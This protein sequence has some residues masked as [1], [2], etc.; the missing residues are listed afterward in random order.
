MK[1][2]PGGEYILPSVNFTSVNAI[3]NT[4][5]KRRARMRSEKLCTLQPINA[6]TA[7]TNSPTATWPDTDCKTEVQG[8]HWRES[9]KHRYF[10]PLFLRKAFCFLVAGVHMTSNA[11][12]RIVG[13]HAL[14]ALG[15]RVSTI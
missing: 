8:E 13:Q 12:A 3:P 5:L 1:K 14:D 11:D 15:H 10:Y 7:V 6:E 4:D 9:L 2:Q